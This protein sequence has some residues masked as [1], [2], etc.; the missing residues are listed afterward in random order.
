MHAYYD[1][2]H[3][4]KIADYDDYIEFYNPGEMKVSKVSISGAFKLFL[5]AASIIL[6]PPD[7]AFSAIPTLLNFK[8]T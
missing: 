3:V 7:P 1:S 6:G 2:D 5:V 8:S 4:I